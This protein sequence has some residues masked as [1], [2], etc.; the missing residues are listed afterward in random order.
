MGISIGVVVAAYVKKGRID[1]SHSLKLGT[2]K[3][4]RK[5]EIISSRIC[6]YISQLKFHT[7]NK[8]DG[9]NS[10]LRNFTEELWKTANYYKCDFD[11]FNEFLE[12]ME[13]GFLQWIKSGNL[14]P[15]DKIVSEKYH[16]VLENQYKSNLPII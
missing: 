1:M 16:E 5:E 13:P 3:F 11:K 8:L 7:G 2:L 9:E 12:T 4:K 15:K 14:E 6:N 10:W